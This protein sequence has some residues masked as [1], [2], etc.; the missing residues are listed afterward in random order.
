[1]SNWTHAGGVVVRRNGEPRL[2]IV[3][4][5][6]NPGHWVL[7]KGHIEAGE[8]AEAAARREV[9]EEAGV[10]ANVRLPLGTLEYETDREHVRARFFLMEYI[11][12]TIHEE[13]RGVYWCP[14]NEALKLLSFADTQAL[15]RKAKQFLEGLS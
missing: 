2:L 15:I 13:S 7:P 14:F 10:D 4:A 1:M 12:E 11:G 9:R 5:K 8:S 3:T 6:Q